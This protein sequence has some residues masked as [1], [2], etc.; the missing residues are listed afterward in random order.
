MSQA[1]KTLARF[2]P[3]VCR[4]YLKDPHI[5]PWCGCDDYEAELAEIDGRQT[6]QKII[7]LACHATW[8]DEY[9]LVTV[10]P[11][12]GPECKACHLP[13]TKAYASPYSEVCECKEETTPCPS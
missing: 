2:D 8:Y 10:T 6:S 1:H 3:E 4:K 5:C 9:D 13:T 11:G 12:D 7:C